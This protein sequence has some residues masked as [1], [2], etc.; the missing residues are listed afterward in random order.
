MPARAS[1]R[2]VDWRA[3]LRT[4]LDI[5]CNAPQGRALR[6]SSFPGDGRP[7]ELTAYGP[8]VPTDDRSKLY[9]RTVAVHG[10]IQRTSPSTCKGGV[11]R[12]A[13][14]DGN[15][16]FVDT[17]KHVPQANSPPSTAAHL[18]MLLAE[19]GQVNGL[20]TVSQV[21]ETSLRDVQSQTLLW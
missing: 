19:V 20:L 21:H 8:V 12:T 9:A 6:R 18:C 5:V 2:H 3:R 16:C 1:R 4:Q 17:C 7:R 11:Q 15:R 14:S 13:G 10:N